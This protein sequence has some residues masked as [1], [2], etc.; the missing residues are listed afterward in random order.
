VDASRDYNSP[1][2][3]ADD[4][5][6][7]DVGLGFLYRCFIATIAARILLLIQVPQGGVEALAPTGSPSV[8]SYLVYCFALVFV[9][10]LGLRMGV[11]RSFAVRSGEGWW[12]AW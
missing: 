10:P 3:N 12:P 8:K 9:V 6:D 11:W 4:A 7:V 5:G 2:Y 1:A